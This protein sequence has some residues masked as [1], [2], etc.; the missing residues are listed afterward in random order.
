MWILTGKII[1]IYEINNSEVQQRPYIE[2]RIQNTKKGGACINCWN[3]TT[4]LLF[5]NHEK[6]L[7]ALLQII[8]LWSIHRFTCIW[9]KISWIIF[10]RKVVQALSLAGKPIP[11]SPVLQNR[12]HL[13][14]VNYITERVSWFMKRHSCWWHIPSNCEV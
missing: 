6:E 1:I 10:G 7:W 9:Y 5:D 8:I 2:L 13:F 14:K 3:T 4:K 11:L 12:L